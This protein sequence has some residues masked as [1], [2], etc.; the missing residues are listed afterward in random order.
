MKY[1]IFNTS[2][3][4]LYKYI[5]ILLHI[6]LTMDKFIIDVSR[7]NHIIFNTN[8][9]KIINVINIGET[10]YHTSKFNI[11][12]F[13]N[14]KTCF[15]VEIRNFCN[16][17]E[18][19][20]LH[21][22]FK[23]PYDNSYYNNFRLFFKKFAYYYKTNNYIIKDDELQDIINKSDKYYDNN[24]EF[25]P[26]DYRSNMLFPKYYTG[27]FPLLLYYLFNNKTLHD[28]YDNNVDYK[29]HLNRLYNTCKTVSQDWE[30]L[31]LSFSF[32]D[33]KN[34]FN[35]MKA[36]SKDYDYLKIV[37]D[38][39][40]N[41]FK[42]ILEKY[43][44]DENYKNLINNF[45]DENINLFFNNIDIP[46]F[47]IDMY[48]LYT[49]FKFEDKLNKYSCI[50]NFLRY[51]YKIYYLHDISKK[52]IMSKS[53]QY[54]YGVNYRINL[55]YDITIYINFCDN[56]EKYD[57]NVIYSGDYHRELFDLFL[58]FLETDD[59]FKQYTVL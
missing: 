4:K 29:E 54:Q 34:D 9:Q 53:R 23:K 26:C 58:Y 32:N 31:H 5:N 28:F 6:V 11:N 42:I 21:Y 18:D 27:L 55:I 36:F 16:S 33:I 52:Y 22:F 56:F 35:N 40:I 30:D 38:D 14:K 48:N 7:V 46:E 3:H 47:I 2:I 15:Y 49:Y 17:K 13:K 50:K 12:N 45:S 10:H 25:I 57:Y 59:N 39:I 44:N 8:N 1:L 19:N 24:W 37:N 43:Y 20:S 41:K 51:Y